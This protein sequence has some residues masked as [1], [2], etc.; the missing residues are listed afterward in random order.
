[1]LLY[2]YTNILYFEA[3]STLITLYKPDTQLI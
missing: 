1:M 2:I 3:F